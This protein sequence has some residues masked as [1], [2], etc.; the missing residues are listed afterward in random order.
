MRWASCSSR[1]IRKY[2]ILHR[3]STG[4]NEQRRAETTTPLISLARNIS[5]GRTH[6]KNRNARRNM[7]AWLPS[8][9]I[10]TRSTY[11]ESSVSA[12]TACRRTGTLPT[13]GSRKRR[14]RDTTMQ[15]FS[16]IA[17]SD[18]SRRTFCSRRHGCSITWE[19]SFRAA[20]L[21]RKAVVSR[22]TAS[23][24]PSCVGCA[25]P[26]DTR[27]PITSRSR[28]AAPCRWAGSAVQNLCRHRQRELK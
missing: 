26:P 23:G 4:W 14:R 24:S 16:W 27:Q 18:R 13:T 10:P 28:R 8:R 17:L 11:W 25:W 1:M 20:L 21:R 15:D 9:A 5:V 12:A 22:S 6:R 7:C 2:K 19:R 3:D